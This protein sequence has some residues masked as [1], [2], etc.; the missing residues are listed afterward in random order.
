MASS[1]HT[2]GLVRLT[3]IST[4]AALAVGLSPGISQAA[5]SR[6]STPTTST[7]AAAKVSEL[8]NKLE[9]LSEQ[10][11]GA[12]INLAKLIAAARVAYQQAEPVDRRYAVVAGQV[13]KI[14][15]AAYKSAPFGEFT[16]FLSSASPEDFLAQL[17]ALDRVSAQRAALIAS[18]SPL[19]AQMDQVKSRAD[20]AVA[21]ARAQSAALT[22]QQTLLTRQIGQYKAL[23]DR[24][25]NTEQFS[26]YGF[27]GVADRSG[28]I[29]LGPLPLPNTVA[30]AKA[31]AAAI[32]VIGDPYV[33]GSAGPNSF[34]CSGL[35]MWAWAHAGVSLPHQS[36]DQYNVL[37]HIPLDQIEPGDLLFFYS[38]I[39]HVAIYVGNDTMIHAPTSGDHVRYAPVDTANLV[40]AGRPG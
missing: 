37:P 17:A 21:A 22:R 11:N 18:V 32:S 26:L 5:P 27:N 29:P 19:K 30:A 28:R 15:V 33:W 31:V 16:A 7:Q 1:R 24:L 14:I 39:H 25:S 2:P 20:Q 6:P 9:Q 35:T 8:G 36:A 40:G 13:S 3:V 4:I 23:Y 34:D 12:K 10:V 38:P